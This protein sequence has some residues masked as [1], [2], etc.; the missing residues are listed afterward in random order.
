ME[1]LLLGELWKRERS[2]MAA[3]SSGV[4]AST[5]ET[6]NFGKMSGEDFDHHKLAAW[7]VLCISRWSVGSKEYTKQ[8]V[9]Y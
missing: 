2:D 8:N 9:Y 4:I 3:V 5:C 6:I 1:T 7:S